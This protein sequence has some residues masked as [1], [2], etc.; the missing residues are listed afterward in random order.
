MA[1]LRLNF[2]LDLAR[3]GHLAGLVRL[4]I[5]LPTSRLHLR[6]DHEL[7]ALDLPANLQVVL[8]SGLAKA[9]VGGMKSGGA[10]E[11]R[12]GRTL[13]GSVGAPA[14]SDRS[15]AGHAFLRHPRHD[16]AHYLLLHVHI[17]A[18]GPGLAVKTSRQEQTNKLHNAARGRAKSRSTAGV[19]ILRNEIRANGQVP[20]LGQHV[21]ELLVPAGVDAKHV[22][23]HDDTA[24]GGRCRRRHVT[25]QRLDGAHTVLGHVVFHHTQGL[26]ALRTAVARHGENRPTSGR[27]KRCP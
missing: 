26:R 12:V 3:K 13:H 16:F 27:R 8:P 6:G 14:E 21:A 15:K 22:G 20:L 4:T 5:G 17:P 25:R 24:G 2:P 19:W 7:R 18:E 10:L 23:E 11:L 1:L 9:L